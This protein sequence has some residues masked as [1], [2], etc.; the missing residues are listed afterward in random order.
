MVSALRVDAY[1]N[2]LIITKKARRVNC[3]STAIDAEWA[4][5]TRDTVCQSCDLENI[6]NVLYGYRNC[7]HQTIQKSISDYLLIIIK[8][9]AVSMWSDVNK[10][11]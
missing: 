2:G 4:Y 3:Q 9:A 1:E 5:N 8:N 10:L 11:T 6:S 7:L